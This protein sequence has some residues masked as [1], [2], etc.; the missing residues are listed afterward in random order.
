MIII[1]FKE[2]KKS[3]YSGGGHYY[4]YERKS[5]RVSGKV[6]KKDTYIMSISQL[7][8]ENE[9]YFTKYN[10]YWTEEPIIECKCYGT[11]INFPKELKEDFLKAV[12]RYKVKH[13]VVGNI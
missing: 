10:F 1:K 11:P 6:K 12:K 7:N 13:S 4:I 9:D 3:F 8:W 5:F 2:N